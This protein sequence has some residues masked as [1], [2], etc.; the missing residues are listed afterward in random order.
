MPPRASSP[1]AQEATERLRAESR[2]RQLA[3]S[4]PLTDIIDSKVLKREL[5]QFYLGQEGQ[6]GASP[7][8]IALNRAKRS[9]ESIAEVAKG[10]RRISKAVT[11]TL[12]ALLLVELKFAKKHNVAASVGSIERFLQ[13]VTSEARRDSSWDIGKVRSLLARGWPEDQN[14]DKLRTRELGPL[15]WW[16]AIPDLKDKEPVR[17]QNI[18][19]SVFRLPPS[20][21]TS[22]IQPTSTT[23]RSASS[24]PAREAAGAT[25]AALR[26][27]IILDDDGD[28]TYAPENAAASASPNE[29]RQVTPWRFG[30]DTAAPFAV[31]MPPTAPTLL[32]STAP[33]LPPPPAPPP[34]ASRRTQPSP[35]LPPGGFTVDLKWNISDY[36][37]HKRMLKKWPRGQHIPDG[38]VWEHPNAHG[39]KVL[40]DGLPL[41]NK[42]PCINCSKRFYICIP[43]GSK[44]CL[45]CYWE[46]GSQGKCEGYEAPDGVVEKPDY[47]IRLQYL[48]EL[49]EAG[50]YPF[51]HHYLYEDGRAVAVC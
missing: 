50:V 24:R 9:L 8:R 25:N 35:W 33:P 38:P 45:P 15:P 49:D 41:T 43:R 6:Q 48:R 12:W 46:K 17:R 26:G 51:P 5:T 31:D 20:T 16:F 19:D 1:A 28:G 3:G 11:R 10:A 44:A 13:T 34:G 40:A 2:A 47:K 4:G 29:G 32:P 42:K 7:G 27:A 30:S 39:L 21:A 36:H 23:S 37:A 14:V 18:Y 22:R